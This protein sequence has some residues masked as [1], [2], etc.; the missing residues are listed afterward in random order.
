MKATVISY[1][2]TGN[3][4]SLA[5]SLAEALDAK[6]IRITETEERTIWK[7]TVDMLLNR[8]P[9]VNYAYEEIDPD[10]T[11]V[12]VAP[13]W[14]GCIASPMRAC[15]KRLKRAI[16]AYAFISI[17]GGADG[18]NPKI[19]KELTSKLRM[20]PAA[21]IDLHIADL[22]PSKP[23]PNR[24]DTS[25]YRITAADI[26]KLT[27]DSVDILHSRLISQKSSIGT[28]NI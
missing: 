8:I 23:K 16:G 1:S 25:K 12:F 5:Q 26:N 22:L 9:K 13:I 15:M 6:H 17:S 27:G 10:G 4:D 20:E 28:S 21:V 2:L 11:I 14:M 18:S 7:T 19:A 3:N 24:N